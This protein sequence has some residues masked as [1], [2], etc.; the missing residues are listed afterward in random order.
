[1][2]YDIVG[3]NALITGGATGIGLAYAYELLKNGLAVSE[4]FRK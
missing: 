2:G 1:M 4:N 3:K